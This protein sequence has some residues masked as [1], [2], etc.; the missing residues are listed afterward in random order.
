MDR[1][2]SSD[3]RGSGFEPGHSI[4]KNTTSLPRS[5]RGSPRTRISE[6]SIR[7][8]GQT[9]KIH[10]SNSNFSTELALFSDMVQAQCIKRP[11]RGKVK[12]PGKNLFVTWYPEIPHRS[13]KHSGETHR[14]TYE[15][16]KQKFKLRS[17]CALHF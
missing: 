7:G 4:S 15:N 10:N 11:M 5:H 9:K 1:S 6:L 12:T 17:M 3:A 13:W 14:A 8:R 16:I 2:S